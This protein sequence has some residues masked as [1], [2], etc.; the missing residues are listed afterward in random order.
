MT[1]MPLRPENQDT[2]IIFNLY[3]LLPSISTIKL[4]QNTINSEWDRMI[5]WIQIHK[6]RFR[7]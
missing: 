3:I 2:T 6:V 7:I 4:P 1:I 5:D